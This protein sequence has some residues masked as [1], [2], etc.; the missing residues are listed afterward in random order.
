[1]RTEGGQSAFGAAIDH[2]MRLHPAFSGVAGANA[3][4]AFERMER[5]IVARAGSLSAAVRLAQDLH[6]LPDFLGNRSPLADPN[7]RGVVV[8]LDLSDRS[9]EHTSEL[10]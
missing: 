4:K 2:M 10:Q 1:W 6:V 5:D 7:A 9:E 8:G 3:E